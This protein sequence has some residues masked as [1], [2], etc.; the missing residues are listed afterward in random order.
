LLDEVKGTTTQFLWRA[1]A[2]GSAARHREAS[3][4]A[5]WTYSQPYAAHPAAPVARDAVPHPTDPPELLDVQM[6]QAAGP[7]QP[8]ADATGGPGLRR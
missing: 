2:L 1:R 6:Q 5:T 3:S 8:L 4:M 7:R